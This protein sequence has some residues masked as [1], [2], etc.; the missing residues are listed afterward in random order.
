ML[1]CGVVWDGLVAGWSAPPDHTRTAHHR[2]QPAVTTSKNHCQG[3]GTSGS[4]QVLGSSTPVHFSSIFHSGLREKR[5]LFMAQRG[6]Y[7]G[8]IPPGGGGPPRALETQPQSPGA[9]SRGVLEV[10]THRRR[11]RA[12]KECA[13]KPGVC[14]GG[15]W[16]DDCAVNPL[17]KHSLIAKVD[18]GGE[19][20]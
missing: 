8:S 5:T 15:R 19:G 3:E 7:S 4:V 2:R 13:R 1:R 6:S 9:L 20:K 14:G 16:L 11:R 18:A 12:G 17:L 10:V